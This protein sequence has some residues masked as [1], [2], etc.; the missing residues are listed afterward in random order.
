VAALGGVQ[1]SR[2]DVV[3][4]LSIQDLAREWGKFRR[5]SPLPM[6]AKNRPCGVPRGRLNISRISRVILQL[7]AD[8][9]GPE[10]L[11]TNERLVERL[12]VVRGDAANLLQRFQ[13]AQIKAIDHLAH[14]LAFFGEP[15]PH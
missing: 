3:R 12:K 9:V 11:K 5:A 8:L 4:A 13:L 7:V 15:H 6:G 10:A 14:V 1:H 2:T